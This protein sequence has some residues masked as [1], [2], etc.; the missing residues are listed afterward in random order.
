MQ[1]CDS[2]DKI[3]RAL[4][5]VLKAEADRI[6]KPLCSMTLMKCVRCKEACEKRMNKNDKRLTDVEQKEALLNEH[7][8][9]YRQR[10]EL[11]K[12]IDSIREQIRYYEDKER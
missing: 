11:D 7:R 3:D 6:E 9:L 10:L 1:G 12:R 8:K 4:R 5:Q 2:M